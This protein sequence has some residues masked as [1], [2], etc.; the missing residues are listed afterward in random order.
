MTRVSLPKSS[1][2]VA[3]L[4]PVLLAL[5]V[6]SGVAALIY[7]TVW[8]QLLEL[9][10]GSSA[11]SIAVL[12]A[13]YMGGMCIGSIGFSRVVKPEH[14]PLKVYAFLEFG[15]GAC[16]I[17]A[18]VTL[19]Y[20]GGIY[21][22]IG[23]HGAAGLAVRGLL[24]AIALLPPTIL[25]GATLPAIS[26]YVESTP[27]GLQWMGYLYG[28]NTLGAVLGTLVAGF[29]LLRA[30]DML[31]AT[32][33][34]VS[35]NAVI[36]GM[37]LLLSHRSSY[38]LETPAQAPKPG[39]HRLAPVEPTPVW[40]V[41]VAI[42]LSGFTALASEVVWTRVL[43]LHLGATVYTYSIILAAV[44][45]GIGVG[46]YA[47]AWLT[48]YRDWTR[49]LLGLCQA[50]LTVTM[51]WAAYFVMVVF[52]VSSNEAA[53]APAQLTVFSHD[54]G[55][56][57]L[58][59]L[60]AA[61][62][63][64]ASFPLALAAASRPGEDPGASVGRVYAA[65]TLGAIVGSLATSLILMAWLGSQ[66][67]LQLLIIS[68]VASSV[69]VLL[70]L[71]ARAK[72][73]GKRA[74]PQLAWLVTV[75]IVLGLLTVFTIR[76][77]PGQLVGYGPASAKWQPG[78]C[79]FVYVGEGMNSSVAISQQS[80]GIMNYHNAGKVQA[81]SQPG[82]LRLERMLGHL[83]TLQPENP[84]NVLVI[85]C[86]AG[87]TAGA[88]SVDPRVEKLTICEIEPLVPKA[89][90][91]YFAA[92]NASVVS[93]PKTRVVI[94]DGRHYLMTSKEK[95]DAITCDPFDPWTKGA[96]SL[97]TVEFFESAKEHLNPGGTITFW[98]P[99]YQMRMA[100][101]KCEIGTFTKVFP[102]SVVWDNVTNGGGDIVLS[103]RVGG[104]PI[105]VD[106]VE[107]RLAE[108]DYAPVR[109]SMASVGFDSAHELFASYAASG[110]DLA[111][112]LSNAHI[113]TDLN[114]RLQYLAGVGFGSD[115]TEH[116]F[117]NI[118]S[119]GTWPEGLFRGTPERID[120]LKA[121]IAS[122]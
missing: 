19:P 30:F 85:G 104:G 3:R 67:V 88:V 108:D 61:L 78:M 16:G 51:A 73:K 112:W 35:V 28:G 39:K 72:A 54:L 66:R 8:F 57:L 90:S 26:R 98:V 69:T 18:L 63:W 45:L 111:P 22:A 2:S 65:N 94:D 9:T 21:L 114:L 36:G 70:P 6:G 59:M 107:R 47:G 33:V 103:A 87:V 49:T 7:E 15:I 29:Y 27:S 77:L 14:N 93:A 105:D 116:I 97:A 52:P 20:A 5:F 91:A 86:G 58:C 40:P 24:S 122:Q 82:D 113:N 79:N 92:H 75:P 56:G 119:F 37:A 31:V 120:A 106:E 53:L 46:S 25:M 118:A 74:V 80:D 89:A 32:L 50:L 62:L 64:G 95:Y 12:L 41:L 34:A 96:A 71:G 83:T 55:Q 1:P 121:E 44:L 11:V 101:A 43:S 42:G 76:P 100:T 81:S 4:F 38:Q 110:P 13:T 117:G 102:N 84:K 17:L 60:P 23:G 48:R 68:A 10:V 99:L 109:E 115:E